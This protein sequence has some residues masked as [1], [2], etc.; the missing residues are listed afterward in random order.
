MNTLAFAG[1]IINGKAKFAGTVDPNLVIGSVI[2]QSDNAREVL[3]HNGDPIIRGTVDGTEYIRD[4]LLRLFQNAAVCAN[5]GA[6]WDSIK[7]QCVKGCE[8]EKPNIV[9]KNSE[10]AC[11]D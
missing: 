4:A 5:C 8:N 9:R 3:K 7:N 11:C 2:R 6:Q 10:S 1:S